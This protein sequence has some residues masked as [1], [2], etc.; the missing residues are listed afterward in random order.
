MILEDLIKDL[1][2]DEQEKILSQTEENKNKS[3][4]QLLKYYKNKS[5]QEILRNLPEDG[6]ILRPMVGEVVKVTQDYK[7]HASNDE[8]DTDGMEIEV[9][10]VKAAVDNDGTG[11]YLTPDKG[12]TCLISLYSFDNVL[13][14]D[15]DLYITALE[16]MRTSKTG[17]ALVCR[18]I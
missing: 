7:K 5:F 1:P 6:T 12:V 11:W 15:G 9:R 4:E 8:H 13:E 18:A 17:R 16:V 10:M 14:F 2:E 3:R